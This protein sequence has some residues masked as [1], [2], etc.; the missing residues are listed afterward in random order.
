M[1]TFL[2]FLLGVPPII[3]THPKDTAIKLVNDTTNV[4]LICEANGVTSYKWERQSGSIPSS[5][6]GVNTNFLYISN[7]KPDDAGKYRCIATNA[8]GSSVSDYA[9]LSI[10]G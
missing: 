5:N 4:S 1:Y 8:S 2:L 10:N 7:L 3:T 6:N 9:Q